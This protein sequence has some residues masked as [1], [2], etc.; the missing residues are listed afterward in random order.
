MSIESG[1]IGTNVPK[2]DEWRNGMV[3]QISEFWMRRKQ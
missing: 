2:A 3:E 1:H